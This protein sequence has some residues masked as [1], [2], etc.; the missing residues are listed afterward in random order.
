MELCLHPLP[1]AV[2]KQLYTCNVK[3]TFVDKVWPVATNI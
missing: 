2:F 1:T 3:I